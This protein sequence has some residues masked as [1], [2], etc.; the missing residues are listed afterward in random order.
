MK[1]K[2]GIIS[3]LILSTWP[4]P[5]AF[6]RKEIKYNFFLH[7]ARL[8]AVAPKVLVELNVMLLSTFKVLCHQM[9]PVVVSGSLWNV[10]PHCF[11]NLKNQDTIYTVR[12]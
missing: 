6:T 3:A 4:L 1:D 12:G 10:L 7:S 2:S 8:I 11:L 5:L 9:I